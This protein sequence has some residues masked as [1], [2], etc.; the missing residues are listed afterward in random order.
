MAFASSL[1]CYINLFIIY[2]MGKRSFIWRSSP[3]GNFHTHVEYCII[4]H[5][6]ICHIDKYRYMEGPICH[7]FGRLGI[8]YFEQEGFCKTHPKSWESFL[9]ISSP[10]WGDLM[11]PH[12]RGLR[13]HQ[14]LMGPLRLTNH[15]CNTYVQYCITFYYYIC[16][17]DKYRYVECPK[18]HNFGRL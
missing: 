7:N 15:N 8:S 17:N 9:H 13:Y 12:A 2:Y 3:G 14:P 10:T 4:I 18:F 6:H 5:Y 1:K 11:S 16:H